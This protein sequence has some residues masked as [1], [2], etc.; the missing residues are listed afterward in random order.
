MEGRGKGGGGRE[1]RRE[2]RDE[3]EGKRRNGRE[4]ERGRKID[5]KKFFCANKV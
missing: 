1:E 2:G 3:R 4:M 5:L